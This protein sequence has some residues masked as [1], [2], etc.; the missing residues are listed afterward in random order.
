M[1]KIKEIKCLYVALIDNVLVSGTY[2]A[3]LRGMG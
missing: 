2:F 3:Y 1:Q